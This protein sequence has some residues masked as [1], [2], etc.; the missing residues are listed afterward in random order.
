M[1]GFVLAAALTV[2]SLLGPVVGE[3]AEAVQTPVEHV[4]PIEAPTPE[5][6][7]GCMAFDVMAAYDS[8]A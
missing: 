5:D 3:P 6:A 1:K 4:M 7:S 2:C 8:I